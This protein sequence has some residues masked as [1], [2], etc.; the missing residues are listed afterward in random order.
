MHAK[1]YK[2]G[3]YQKPRHEYTIK[4]KKGKIRTMLRHVI[5]Q[6]CSTTVDIALLRC[7]VTLK[8][9]YCIWSV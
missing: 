5:M 8:P 7:S 1:Y 3:K 2:P 4:W 6:D 9:G